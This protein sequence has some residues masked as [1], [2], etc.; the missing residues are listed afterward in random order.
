MVRKTLVLLCLCAP[1][2]LLQNSPLPDSRPS[3]PESLRCEYL[4][5]PAAVQSATPRF[6]WKLNDP[7]PGARQTAWQIL[8]ATSPEKLVPG[9]ADRWDSGKVNS[10]ETIQIEYAGARVRSGEINYWKARVWDA[11][12]MPSPWGEIATFRFGL[13]KPED[14]RA[15]WIRH[16]EPAPDR[17][18]GDGALPP[19]LF[20][21]NFMLERKPARATL[22]AAAR[23]LY[24]IKINGREIG[25][26]ELAPDWTDYNQTIQYRAFDAAP[27]LTVG[28]QKITILAGD[29]WYSGRIGM[30]ESFA[31]GKIKR[32]I[33]GRRPE[34][35]AQLQIEF[36]DGKSIVIKTDEQWKSTTEGPFRS[37]DLLDGIVYDGRREDEPPAASWRPVLA[38]APGGEKLVAQP[39]EPVDIFESRAPVSPPRMK[40]DTYIYDFGQN[41][42]GIVEIAVSA[43]KGAG[44]A[45]RH[46]EAL[47][48]YGE[49][50]TA[51]LR[52]APQVD[53]YI[54]GRD[55]P[56]LFRPKFTFHGFRYISISGCD[57]PPVSVTAL[58][59]RSNARESSHFECS[60]A[61][62]NK[63]WRN[64]LWTLRGN[65]LGVPTDCPQRDERL[66]W[67]GD[68]QAFSR[69][70]MLQM[71]LAAFF[72]KWLADVREAQA[73]DGRFPDFA[74]HPFQKNDQFAGTPAWGDAGVFV[75]W[76]CYIYY[77][78][79]RLLEEHFD[80]ARRWIDYIYGKNDN[81]YLWRNGR[82]NDYG[83]WLNASTFSAAAPSDGPAAI[84]GDIA[85]DALASAF[86]VQSA[87]LVAKMAGALGRSADEKKYKQIASLAFGA[88]VNEFVR[89]DG[90]I[91][92]H[93][94]SAYALALTFQLVPPESMPKVKESL[95]VSLDEYKGR[96]STGIQTTHRLLIE[97]SRN[98]FHEKAV[99]IATSR[100]FPSW[101]YMIDHGATTIWERWDGYVAGRGFQDPGMNSMN[102]YAL[103]SVG[104]W[105]M[106]C[107]LG[108][109]P[110]ENAP[111]FKHFNIRPGPSERL[112]WAG[113]YYDSI[114][115]RISVRWRID[116]RRF[117]ADVVVPANTSATFFQPDGPA[118]RELAPGAH[119]L[120]FDWDRRT[121]R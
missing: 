1:P 7:R 22:Y 99:E 111:G 60:N 75:P 38:S 100:T 65:T 44:I 10:D 66:G 121:V 85:K 98:G 58:A 24:D 86:F 56:N 117:I 103:G 36:D 112:D 47:D 89:D 8:V 2:V 51:N 68:M 5:N 49:L 32:G 31:P 77:A 87:R 46:G 45:V 67:M 29:G 41:L 27:F 13:L 57:A 23:G 55:G 14:W 118:R 102:H 115:G 92:N 54:A 104:Q 42:V 82:G 17:G 84:R 48:D 4:V 61:I 93:T 83:D 59:M 101:G 28:E 35:I 107:V 95:A 94:Q 119:H 30:A 91:A 105:L 110:D 97:C 33:Y 9:L 64:I 76:D 73:A 80:A 12:G 74:P 81:N 108:I 120:E 96:L 19:V 6:F 18:R 50:Y 26:P 72:T 90:R 62:L 3:P 63:L 16:A 79:R 20:K 52:G 109:E 78:D 53:R 21:T 43:K 69:T 71:D 15:R 114:R 11:D 116:G 25:V 88:F 113:G 39:N 40:G 37:A 106:N 34:A 70:A